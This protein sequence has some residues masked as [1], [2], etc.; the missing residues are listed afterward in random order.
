MARFEYD[1]FLSH[2]SKDKETVHELAKRLRADGLS[3]WLDAWIIELGDSIPAKLMSGLEQSRVL[4]MMLSENFDDSDWAEY[5]S[6]TF[7]FRDPKNTERRFIPVR[8]DA[9][10]I[11]ESLRQFAY[12]DWSKRDDHAYQQLLDA[13]RTI[14]RAEAPRTPPTADKSETPRMPPKLEPP[15]SGENLRGHVENVHDAVE[16]LPEQISSLHSKQSPFSLGYT[17][18]IR[19]VAVSDDGRVDQSGYPLWPPTDPDVPDYGIRL[20]GSIDSLRFQR[21]VHDLDLR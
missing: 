15:S 21:A 20:L 4:L 10:P 3:V 17:D 16:R 5:E 8:L 9:S 7:L 2:N 6:G 14:H 18:W 11:R 13:C 19:S 12:L 1:V